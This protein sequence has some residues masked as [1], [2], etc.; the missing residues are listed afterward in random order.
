MDSN[1]YDLGN[2]KQSNSKTRS[3]TITSKKGLQS[4]IQSLELANGIKDSLINVG[5]TTTDSILS[6]NTTEI[7]KLLGTDLY[8][9][10]LSWKKLK[11]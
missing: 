2:A 7:S 5:F 4:D 11:E 8:V 10:K 3:S 6:S 9:A 1:H